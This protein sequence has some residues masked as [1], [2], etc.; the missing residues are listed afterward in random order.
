[1]TPKEPAYQ[2]VFLSTLPDE[3]LSSNFDISSEDSYDYSTLNQRIKQ[4]VDQ[5]IMRRFVEKLGK[6]SYKYPTNVKV[7]SDLSKC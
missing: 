4:H 1:M 7:V 6:F 5:D 2:N 3:I